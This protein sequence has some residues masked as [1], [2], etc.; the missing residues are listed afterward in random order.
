[1]AAAGRT[2]EI[3]EI[4]TRTTVGARFSRSATPVPA[5]CCRR[6]SSCTPRPPRPISAKPA[7]TRAGSP[8]GLLERLLG[9]EAYT[10]VTPRFVPA[11]SFLYLSRPARNA[12]GD[13]T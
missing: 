2:E 9:C 5:T 1:M 10:V 12:S 13:V 11:T 7:G 4:S 6:R 8:I 3:R